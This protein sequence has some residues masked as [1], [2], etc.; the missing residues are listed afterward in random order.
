[1]T[2]IALNPDDKKKIDDAEA[3]LNGAKNF[4]ID[5]DESFESA[6]KMLKEIKSK[7]KEFD[8][9]R[10][11]L[12][13]PI[14]LAAKTIEDFFRKPISF[15]TDAEQTY[16][17]NILK[18]RKAIERKNEETKASTA[19]T[20]QDLQDNVL[21]ALKENDYVKYAELSLEI[22]ELK[23]NEKAVPKA[24]GVSFRDNWK[25]RI[26]DFPLAV[27]AVANGDI[28]HD[29]LMANESNL[30]QLARAMKDTV[31]YPGIEFYNDQIVTVKTG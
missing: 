30:N 14:N 12:K 26:T 3:Y 8:A 28:P 17:A 13:A 2:D 22:T 21:E 20:S 27:L 7:K 23:N 24:D 25:G 15:L 6:N 18:Y 1:M 9:M 5:S 11:D 29:V 16:K 19:I 31:K 4:V 10:K